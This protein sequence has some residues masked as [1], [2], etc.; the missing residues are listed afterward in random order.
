[1]RLVDQS[2][3]DFPISVQVKKNVT[4]QLQLLGSQKAIKKQSFR[5]SSLNECFQQAMT[6]QQRK[7]EQRRQ[8][9]AQLPAH[10]EVQRMEQSLLKLLKV[11]RQT[12]LGPSC[13]NLNK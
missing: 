6:Q 9:S 13:F 1:M 4:M 7:K 5:F 10:G 8:R 11:G 2:I 3:A 12:L